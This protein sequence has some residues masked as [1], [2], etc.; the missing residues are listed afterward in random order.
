MDFKPLKKAIVEGLRGGASTS[1]LP[2][3]Q[4][5]VRY[6]A[7]EENQNPKQ[8]VNLVEKFEHVPRN[9]RRQNGAAFTTVEFGPILPTSL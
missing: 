5:T 8:A 4:E 1:E 2:L 6:K 9:L 3:L 7:S